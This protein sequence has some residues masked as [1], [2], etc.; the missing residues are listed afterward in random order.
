VDGPKGWKWTVARKWTSY[1]I[2]LDRPVKPFKR[3][4]FFPLHRSVVAFLAV[5]FWIEHRPISPTVHFWYFRPCSLIYDFL[6]SV[7]L[8]DQSNPHGQIPVKKNLRPWISKI[9]NF[10]KYVNAEVLKT[11]SF[12]KKR[13]IWIVLSNFAVGPLVGA[14]VPPSLSLGH[15]WS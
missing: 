1:F 13:N 11:E 14:P 5:Q 12:F 10:T 8:T 7:V 15:F 4:S 9:S 3:S 2:P 6:V